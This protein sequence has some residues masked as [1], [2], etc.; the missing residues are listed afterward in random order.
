MEHVWYMDDPSVS[1]PGLAFVGMWRVC[2]YHLDA[3]IRT[4]KFCHRYTYSD[5]FLPRDIRI[6]QHLLLIA[7]ILGFLGRG[8]TI[9][10]LR[11]MFMGI[12]QRH[13]TCNLFVVTGLLNII[14]GVLVAVAVHYN[15]QS[16]RNSQGIAF[17]PS[18]RLPFR[19]DSQETGCTALVASVGAFLMLLSGPFLLS[20]QC[21]LGIRVHP[22]N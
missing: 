11:N 21:P 22:V 15:Y 4:A 10:A 7:T 2:I 18:F 8:L 19:P 3:N 17:L 14:A 12:P 1:P 6:S 5:D 20:G 9:L 13:N 16:V